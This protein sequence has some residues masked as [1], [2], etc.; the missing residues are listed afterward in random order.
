[1]TQL[2]HQN[3]NWVL[4][5]SI[6]DML[7]QHASRS[8][9]APQS[10]GGVPASFPSIYIGANGTSWAER[11]RTHGDEVCRSKISAINTVTRRSPI[12]RDERQPK[13]N[14]HLRVCSRI[15]PRRALTMTRFRVCHG[16][17]L[18]PA[19]N[20]PIGGSSGIQNVL[21]GNNGHL[22]RVR[23]PR[24][25]ADRISGAPGCPS[26]PVV[27]HDHDLR[28]KSSSSTPRAT[29]S[30]SVV[31]TE[32][33]AGFEDLGTGGDATNSGHQLTRPSF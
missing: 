6:S 12:T 8:S 29:A 13:L 17:A 2:H 4:R 33:L 24:A 28:L 21:S 23:R 22:E 15:R 19:N 11:T 5:R 18:K 14:A 16:L 31:L 1:V 30:I 7:Q 25:A 10:G 20:N 27:S 32:R 3:N 26:R 9:A